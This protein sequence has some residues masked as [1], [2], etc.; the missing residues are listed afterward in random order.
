MLRLLPGP[1]RALAL[2]ILSH[3]LLSSR[4]PRSPLLTLPLA[5]KT[6]KPP[7]PPLPAHY[8]LSYQMFSSTKQCLL[9]LLLLFLLLLHSTLLLQFHISTSSSFSSSPP[10]RF[11]FSRGNTLPRV[12]RLYFVFS[13]CLPVFP[14][15]LYL[16]CK[17][18]LTSFTLFLPKFPL[19]LPL[20]PR[21]FGLCLPRSCLC[22]QGCLA[23][24]RTLAAS[25]N[26]SE[27]S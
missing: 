14:P 7:T 3:I 15:S 18:V 9:L 12:D 4:L 8:R 24:W 21:S 22:S 11:I 1:A 25:P 26:S 2:L 10:P 20:L 17:P 27:R 6:T 5:G 19:P 13:V 23:T 16:I